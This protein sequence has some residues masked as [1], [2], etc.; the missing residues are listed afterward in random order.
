MDSSIG[1]RTPRSGYSFDSGLDFGLELGAG[2]G[3]GAVGLVGVGVE[4][5][6]ASMTS[7]D[8]PVSSA[9][10]EF[11]LRRQHMDPNLPPR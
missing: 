9:L 8:F 6:G 3:A 1:P 7:S 10:S 5:T 11:S 4:S 2:A